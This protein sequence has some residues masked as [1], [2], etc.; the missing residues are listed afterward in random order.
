M[1]GAELG[2]RDLVV[3]GDSIVRVPRSD[4]GVLLPDECLGTIAELDH[5][6][7]AG[8]R[9]GIA[10]L[11]DALHLIRVGSASPL[12]TE[13]RL[14]AAEAGLPDPELDVEIRDGGGKLL[15]ISEVVYR[16][17]RTVVEI[18]GD[19]HRTDRRQWNHD[20]DKYAAYAAEGWEVV[21]LTSQHI[22]GPQPR[23]VG[24]VR[25]VLLRRGWTPG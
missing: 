12:E 22:R 8:R 17:C 15:G 18:E 6:V 2:V 21:R 1:L 14:D 4:R 23:A 24:V 7:A 20:I 9:V 11:R 10:K 5:A 19:H 16:R 3:L 25:S 13:Y